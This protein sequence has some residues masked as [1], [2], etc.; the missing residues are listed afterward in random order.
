M[1]IKLGTLG[2]EHT[3]Y[4]ANVVVRDTKVMSQHTMNDGSYKV[5]EAPEMKKVFDITLVKVRDPIHPNAENLETEYV[6]GTTLNLIIGEVS[7]T[8][9]WIGELSLPVLGKSADN[10]TS[11]ILIEV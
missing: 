5:Q 6:K 3:F 1:E 9:K 8:V 4:F 10:G 2:S 7:Y 11:I